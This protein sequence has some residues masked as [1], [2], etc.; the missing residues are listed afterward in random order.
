MP[1]KD[2]VVVGDRLMNY[3][4]SMLSHFSH[5]W[6]FADVRVAETEKF[7]F[8]YYEFRS[9][10]RM[11]SGESKE[12][13]NIIKITNYS[14]IAEYMERIE[15]GIGK[16]RKS[17]RSRKTPAGIESNNVDVSGND[18]PRGGKCQLILIITITTLFLAHRLND[19]CKK[20][21]KSMSKGPMP[22]PK[23]AIILMLG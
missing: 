10:M 22:L 13:P 21:F 2:R 3:V 23:W 20:R 1:K 7:L 14:A 12:A 4:L 17:V 8:C 15:K 19:L 6:N 18:K 11:C 5:A 9:L 16:W